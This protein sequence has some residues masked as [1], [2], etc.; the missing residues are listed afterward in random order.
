MNVEPGAKPPWNARDTSGCPDVFDVSA[1]YSLVVMPPT[2]IDG[3][4]V[5]RLA[6][7]MTCPLRTSMTTPAAESALSG[8]PVCGSVWPR[9]RCMAAASCCSSTA[10]TRASMFVTR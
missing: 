8:L 9:A 1:P 2:Q 7:A 6:I 4:Y 5:G 10:W 3:S